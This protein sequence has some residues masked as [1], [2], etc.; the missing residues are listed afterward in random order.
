MYTVVVLYDCDV[1]DLYDITLLIVVIVCFLFPIVFMF[2]LSY[3]HFFILRLLRPVLILYSR[4][5]GS[6]YI[7]LSSTFATNI[8]EVFGANV[9]ESLTQC[10]PEYLEY[11]ITTVCKINLKCKKNCAGCDLTQ[12]AWLLKTVAI[13]LKVTAA[14]Q[15]M[16]QLSSIINALVIDKSLRAERHCGSSATGV[17]LAHSFK[18]DLGKHFDFKKSE[19]K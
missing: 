2:T 11:I 9:K 1:S 5:Y 19:I 7:K 17:Q 18:N 13:E 4:S 12:T 16:S 3:H 6:L 15:Q 8:L 14:H 10:E